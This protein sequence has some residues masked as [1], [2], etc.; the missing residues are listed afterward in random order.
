FRRTE[1]R[2]HHYFLN[3]YKYNYRNPVKAGIVQ[4]VEEYPYST[5]QGLLGQSR[6]IIPIEQDYTLFSNLE[7]TLKWLNS[8]SN[9]EY[10]LA[11]KR[12]FRRKIFG[13]PKI[14]SRPHPLEID[15]L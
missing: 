13:L 5:L 1:I 2:S 7:G 4:N 6:L 15:L 9:P 14:D 3:A 11:I 12:G 8:P 10:D